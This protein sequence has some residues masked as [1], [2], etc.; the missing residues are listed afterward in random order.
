MPETRQCE[1]VAGRG[2]GRRGHLRTKQ[3]SSIR[4]IW[5]RLSAAL[6]IYGGWTRHP[7]GHACLVIGGLGWVHCR[8][9]PCFC[10]CYSPGDAGAEKVS[11]TRLSPSLLLP[12]MLQDTQKWC[13]LRQRCSSLA[14]SQICH[15]ESNGVFQSSAIIFYV[16]LLPCKI[17]CSHKPNTSTRLEIEESRPQSA[18]IFL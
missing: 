8:F 15:Q 4:S 10:F 18:T 12:G 6:V 2:G 11:Q 1:C 13:N 5:S 16:F 14:V 9:R 3:R 17:L 7:G